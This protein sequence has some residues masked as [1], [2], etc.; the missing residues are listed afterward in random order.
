MRFVDILNNNYQ[1]NAKTLKFL[2][3]KIFIK[4]FV[5]FFIVLCFKRGIDKVMRAIKIR[6]YRGNAIN[7]GAIKEVL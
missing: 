6:C 2:L 3:N 1:Q 5:Q 4:H 7:E